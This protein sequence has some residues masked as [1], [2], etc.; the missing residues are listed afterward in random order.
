VCQSIQPRGFFMS[1]IASNA[2]RLYLYALVP[3][4]AMHAQ[5][6]NG[7][8]INNQFAQA[9]PKTASQPAAFSQPSVPTLP[10]WP[11]GAPGAQGTADDDK[12]TLAVYLPISNPTHSAVIIAPGGGY[13]HLA[14]QKEG[15]DIAQ[16][17]NERGVAAF[18]L[19][20]RLGPKY[21][22]PI[23]LHDAQ[24]AIRMV[25][26]G[27]TE[28]GIDSKHIGIWGFSAGGHLAA[29]AGTMYQPA[30][31]RAT[32]PIE[33]QS[34]R[35][36][37]LVLAYPVITMEDPEVHK[38]SRTNLLGTAPDPALIEA[39]S[40]QKH[41]T[42]D[43]PPTFLISTTDDGTVPVM[44]S[45]FFYSALVAVKVPAELH[46]FQHGPH[47]IG[48]APGFPDLKG[49]PELLATWMRARGYMAPAS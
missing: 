9:G 3:C 46:I 38:G 1:K 44:N 2:F 22:H 11:A 26:A 49:W 33:R 41:I 23:E 34:E 40:P 32:D 29:S 35:P 25:R 36:D 19:K 21:H 27:A 12:P 39:L 13:Q 20:Y 48:L 10:L 14:M 42:S 4:L 18:V 37:F 6:R 17:L 45:V 7:S 30:N 16:W 28:Y 24:R 5:A 47:G 8:G 43:T 31:S 15:S